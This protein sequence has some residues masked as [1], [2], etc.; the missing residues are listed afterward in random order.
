MDKWFYNLRDSKLKAKIIKAE[1][2]KQTNQN[3]ISKDYGTV[4]KG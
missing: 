1:T 4:T 2:N 3:R